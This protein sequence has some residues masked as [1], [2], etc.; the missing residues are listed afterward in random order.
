MESGA[1]CV[2]D[3]SYASRH[4]RE[5]FPQTLIE[6]ECERGSAKLGADYSITVVR[7]ILSCLPCVEHD[8]V[9]LMVMVSREREG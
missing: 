7:D 1:T 8:S 5:L 6:L 4:D 3:I 9:A 2:V